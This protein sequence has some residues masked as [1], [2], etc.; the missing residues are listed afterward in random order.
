MIVYLIRSNYI[1]RIRPV[2]ETGYPNLLLCVIVIRDED[3]LYSKVLGCKGTHEC[4]NIG[5]LD[6]NKSHR[7][8][9]V[10][11]MP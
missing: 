2:V 5:E 6:G 7:F 8:G 4:R 11:Q 10:F 3:S 9:K 1:F